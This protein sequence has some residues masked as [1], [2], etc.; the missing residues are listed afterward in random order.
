VRSSFIPVVHAGPR[1]VGP[2]S[3]S[4]IG[5]TPIPGAALQGE[6]RLIVDE[7]ETPIMPHDI[8][9]AGAHAAATANQIVPLEGALRTT[10][11][12]LAVCAI[13]ASDQAT[14][15]ALA[16]RARALAELLAD[17]VSDLDE[18]DR[19]AVAARRTA[20]SLVERLADLERLHADRTR[21]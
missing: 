2:L 16:E 14:F 7:P 8:R 20:A 10:L 6:A 21:H 4:G 5:A 12:A 3:D 15:D 13:R 1:R 19:A 9:N 18:D 17:S 11:R